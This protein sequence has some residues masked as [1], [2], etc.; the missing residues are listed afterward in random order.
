MIE[1]EPGI[2]AALAAGTD[3]AD[4]R[5]VNRN[6][7]LRS[8]VAKGPASRA[9]LARRT[10]MSRPT[11]SVIANELL[12][13][14]VLSEGSRVSSGGA[15]GTLLQI[16]KDTGLIVAADLRKP[17]RF[18]VATVSM[19]ADIVTTTSAAAKTDV[20]AADAVLDFTDRIEPRSLIGVAIAVP[21]DVAVDGGDSASSL[22]RELL[23]RLRDRLRVPVIAVSPIEAITV[24]SVRDTPEDVA[25]HATVDLVECAIGLIDERG[26]A[27]TTIGSLRHVVTAVG[28][29]ICNKC[30]RPCLSAALNTAR[31][32]GTASD[33]D[34]A[35]DALAAAL[36]PLA[37]AL[38]LQEIAIAG[39]PD[40]HGDD[41]LERL[42]GA[43][44]Q[45]LAS[46]QQPAVRACRRGED[47]LLSGAAATLLFRRMG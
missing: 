8:I 33:R 9:E 1:Q 13:T 46:D 28:G 25:H 17:A 21:D 23:S 29:P 12:A 24:A 2:F 5:R 15:P 16:A 10:G 22:H 26:P 47:G 45:H 40:Q 14:G 31:S 27:Q 42:H 3:L 35:A 38:E 18:P 11:V 32:K 7:I 44:Q 41:L 36:A 43:L 37:A 34:M 39:L 30:A 20:D 4:T 6:K 19:S